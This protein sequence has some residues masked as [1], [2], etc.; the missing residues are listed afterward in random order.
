MHLWMKLDNNKVIS[1]STG[2]NTSIHSWCMEHGWIRG[3]LYFYALANLLDRSKQ[4]PE[5]S[6]KYFDLR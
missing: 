3:S 4:I 1:K 5:S 2:Y 6:H